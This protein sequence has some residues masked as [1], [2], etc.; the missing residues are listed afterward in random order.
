MKN[1]IFFLCF[2]A[3]QIALAQP[4]YSGYDRLLRRHVSKS[5]AVNY[6]L[7]K[8]NKAGLD[9]VV[10]AFQAAPPQKSWSSNQQLAYWLN[11]YN[12]FTLKLIVDNYPT[13]SIMNLDGGKTWDVKRI[14]IGGKKYSL[15][16]IENTIIRPQFKD[17]RI[18]FALNCAAKSCPPLHNEA[19]TAKNVQD[20]LEKR[21][22]AFVRS[23]AMSLSQKEVK[24]S[25]IFEWYSTDFG[26]LV[27]FL[28]RYASVKINPDAKI[29]Y[30]EYDWKLNQ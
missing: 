26:D 8:T 18:H 7:L 9:S 19:F 28:N 10:R 16:D 23:S 4:D 29:Q 27:A 5:G 1:I 25:K 17:A 12:V 15:N 20:L 30:Q 11:T 3:A 14:D 22:R 21:T 2:F 6:N 13:T 24:I